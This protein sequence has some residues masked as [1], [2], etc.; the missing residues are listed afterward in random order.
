MVLEEELAY[1]EENKPRLLAEHAGKYV[2]IRGR[3]LAG[4]FDTEENAYV[5]GLR[6][7]GNTPFLI[8]QVLLDEPAAHLPALSLGLLRVAD[9]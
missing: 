8:K 9:S 4:T 1:F 2:L 5:E 6:R 7:F 3:E